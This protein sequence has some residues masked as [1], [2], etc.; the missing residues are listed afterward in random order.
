MGVSINLANLHIE[1]VVWIKADPTTVFDALTSS[2]QIVEY[3]PLDKVTSSWSEDSELCM[4]GTANGQTFT[5]YGLID[6]L[7]R[8]KAFAYKYWSDNHGTENRPENHVSVNYQLQSD[9]G[10]TR[11]EMVQSNLPSQEYWAVM[12]QAWDG[13]LNSLKAYVESE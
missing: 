13:L 7:D 8:P 2:E 6:V 9:G 1:K 12:N 10:G 5:D 11:V 4:Q 3:F